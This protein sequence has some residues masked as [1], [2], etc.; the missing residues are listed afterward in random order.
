MKL[1]DINIKDE[2]IAQRICEKNSYFS[3]LF[4]FFQTFL[5][6]NNILHQKSLNHTNCECPHKRV[7]KYRMRLELV[8]SLFQCKYICKSSP[9]Y[10]FNKD[11]I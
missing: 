5:T 9:L 4:H 7:S 10:I 6:S 2:K 8:N 11:I 3:I 1:L